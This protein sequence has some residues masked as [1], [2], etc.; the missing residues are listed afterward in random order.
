MFNLTLEKNDL[1]WTYLSK[2]SRRIHPNVALVTRERHFAKRR[3]SRRRFRLIA[4]R[5]FGLVGRTVVAV[6]LQ[7]WVVANAGSWRRRW[8][9]CWRRRGRRQRR[10]R[11][12]CVVR[13]DNVA[14]FFNNFFL[15]AV[16]WKKN[17]FSSR[18]AFL[19][20]DFLYIISA[21]CGNQKKMQ[22]SLSIFTLVEHHSL[23]L[24]KS[25]N[26]TLYGNNWIFVFKINRS[27]RS[28]SSSKHNQK[29][30]F[31]S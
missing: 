19:G 1:S 13:C 15:F 27:E 5:L 16:V 12:I 11:R 21:T 24:S 7:F 29:V 25:L 6:H 31:K 30:R 22:L 28:I 2:L 26:L 18:T 14:W 17:I 4:I 8:R 9:R 23:K 3:L 10:R 20:K